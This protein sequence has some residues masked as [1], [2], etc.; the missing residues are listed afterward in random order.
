MAAEAEVELMDYDI[1]LARTETAMSDLPAQG[2]L[3]PFQVMRIIRRL[4]MAGAAGSDAVEY[5]PLIDPAKTPA[6]CWRHCCANTWPA[7]PMRCG[8][9]SGVWWRKSGIR[10]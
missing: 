8:A 10:D 5:A 9:A 6:T 3:P 1:T 4:G 7:R 2:G